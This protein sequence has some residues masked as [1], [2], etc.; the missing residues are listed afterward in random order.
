MSEQ[1]YKAIE[2]SEVESPSGNMS[3]KIVNKNETRLK[4]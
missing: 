1:A 4:Y 3:E 2:N